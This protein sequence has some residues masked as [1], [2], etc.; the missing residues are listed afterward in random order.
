MAEV[1]SLGCAICGRPAQVHPV[2]VPGLG[3]RANHIGGTFPL[4]PDHH[5]DGG[6]GV[7]IHAGRKHWVAIYG[8]EQQFLEEVK[9]LLH[10]FS[11]K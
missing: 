7:A 5:L 2:Y 11:V 9:S 10:G 3:I 1:A 8:T 6:Y 4:C